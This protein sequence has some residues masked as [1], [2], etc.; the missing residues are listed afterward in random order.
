ML[1]SV[2]SVITMSDA[3]RAQLDEAM[4]RGYVAAYRWLRPRTSREFCVEI[5]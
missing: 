5:D 1:G 4:Q 2:V 3:L